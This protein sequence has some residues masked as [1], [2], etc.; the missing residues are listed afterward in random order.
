MN[1]MLK[2]TA[3]AALFCTVAGAG[4]AGVAQARGN[5]GLGLA[6]AAFT[7]HKAASTTHK[8]HTNRADPFVGEMKI[9]VRGHSV[10]VSCSGRYSARKPVVVLVAG[11]GDGL[12]KMAD[13]QKT[14]SAKNRVCSYDR[15]GEG[16]SDKPEGPQSLADTGRVLTGVINRVAGD[17]PVV[18][19][20]HSLGGLI[21]ARYT[22]DHT[23]KVKG[24]VLMDAT[25]PTNGADVS[26]AIPESAT[27]DAADLR[28]Q[29]LAVAQGQNPENLVIPDGKVRSAGWIPAQVIRHGQPYL[30]QFPVYGPTLEADWT[31]GQYAWTAVSHRSTIRVA[32]NSGHYIYVDRKDIAVDAIQQVVAQATPRHGGWWSHLGH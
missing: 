1:R 24:L 7:T 3:V 27:G 11:L 9:N 29:T 6:G 26:A 31:K 2:A 10:N 28:A 25:T 13:L 8:G 5:D 14:L 32:E 30:A 15:L 19:A 22:P 17:A 20:G 21:A 18:L 16:K 12:D 4:Y 23:D